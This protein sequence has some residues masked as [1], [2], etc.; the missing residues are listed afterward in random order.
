MPNFADFLIAVEAELN[1]VS[2][3][4]RTELIRSSIVVLICLLV[5]A[6]VIFGFDL[7]WRTI[8]TWIG[9]L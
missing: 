6:S 8:F 7:I 3:P 1:K 9:V 5:L 2:W 4:T